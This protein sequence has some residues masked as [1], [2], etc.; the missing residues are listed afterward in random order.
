MSEAQQKTW[1]EIL[2]A[3][4]A[5]GPAD[6]PLA[7][8]AEAELQKRLAEARAL[9]DG[10]RPVKD[11]GRAG[12][13]LDPAAIEAAALLSVHDP[14][15]H[16]QLQE[17][18]RP[19]RI[20]QNWKRAIS[21][22]GKAMAEGELKLA[23][24]TLLIA[25]AGELLDLWHDGGE[26]WCWPV[27]HGPGCCWRLPSAEVK[28]HLLAAYGARHQLTL[29]DGRKAPSAPG[30]Q[31]VAEAL[32]QLEAMAHEGPRRSEPALRVAGDGARLVLDLCR[33]DYSVAEVTAAGWQVVKPSPLALRR[34]KD[35]RP[36]PLPVQGAGNALGELRALLG[37]AGEDHAA[38]WALFVGF[39]FAAIRPVPPYFV[40]VLAGEQGTGKS[41]TIKALRLPVDPH[42]T[43]IQP[44]PRTE[45]D[46]F[47]N[48]DGQWL[49]AY[50]NLSSLDQHWSDAFCRIATG[51]GYSKRKL[52]SDRDTASFQVA[53]PQVI[54]SI[55]DVAAAPDLLDRSLLAQ[56]SELEGFQAEEELLAAVA[57][58][59][60]RILGQLLD[61]AAVALRDQR[62]VKL[63]TIPRMV[64]PT[65]WVEAGAKVLGL[66]PEQFLCAYLDSQE[67][68]GEMALE[69]SLIGGPLRD[70]LDH[71][72]G[73]ALLAARER[74]AYGGPLG[75]K[76]TAKQLLSELNEFT[77]AKPIHG[78]GWPR[79]P[80]AMSGALRRIAPALRKLGYAVEFLRGSDTAHGR[81]IA[82]DTEISKARRSAHDAND[83]P[84]RPNRPMETGRGC[85]NRAGSGVSDGSDGSDGQ[86]H[87]QKNGGHSKAGEA[88]PVCGEDVSLSGLIMVDGATMCR[89]CAGGQDD[90]AP[91]SPGFVV[92]STCN[93]LFPGSARGLRPEQRCPACRRAHRSPEFEARD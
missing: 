68:A 39:M 59:A 92:C 54:T 16:W 63:S 55:V 25:L 17:E 53:R 31:G 44:K 1:E 3:A 70:M 40:L 13:F 49:T 66:D 24:K 58:L 90:A 75:F 74:R 26:A 21:A 83:R 9:L 8:P 86:K 30:R 14:L 84:N 6:D 27:E 51:S 77:Q 37:F 71:R 41:T 76:G 7:D 81:L 11:A 60:P 15:Y 72:D 57:D 50:D 89:A 2:A 82:I 87:T 91:A 73:L 38:F 5:E 28:R 35:M 93:G 80:R 61:A 42:K 67:R 18:L 64:G 65:R 46:L 10:L 19:Q 22:A 78:R 79:T 52:H 23:E 29:E 20:L 32:D 45:D 4:A 36:L 56:M 34:G 88:C 69:A 48:C 47:V 12:R 62:K 33:D 43:D 85:S